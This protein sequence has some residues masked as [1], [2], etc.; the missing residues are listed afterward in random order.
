[1]YVPLSTMPYDQVIRVI[2]LLGI[3]VAPRVREEIDKWEAETEGKVG[4]NK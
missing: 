2:E 4:E 3:E 1:M